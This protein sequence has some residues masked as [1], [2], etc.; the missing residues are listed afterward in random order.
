[1]KNIRYSHTPH[2]ALDPVDQPLPDAD[3][4]LDTLGIPSANV[5]RNMRHRFEL[6]ASVMMALAAILA[7]WSTYEAHQWYGRSVRNFTDA[8]LQLTSSI[9]SHIQS[10]SLIIVDLMDFQDWL[11]AYQRGDLVT[12]KS[13]ESRFSDQFL[14]LFKTWRNLPAVA[15]ADGPRSHGLNTELAAQLVASQTQGPS[16]LLIQQAKDSFSSAEK[17]SQTASDFLVAG[18]LFG[19]ALILGI[20]SIRIHSAGMQI[21]VLLFSELFTLA[22]VATILLL[23]AHFGGF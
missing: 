9:H 8:N 11:T 5:I 19:L 16:E 6:I 7:A 23:P 2:G 22:G 18:S 21:A 4:E 20:V 15:N 13:I 10:D 12:A 17:A 3:W 14:S 1:M